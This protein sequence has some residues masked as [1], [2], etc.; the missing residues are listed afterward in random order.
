MQWEKDFK[1]ILIKEEDFV[2]RWKLTEVT[3]AMRR[4]V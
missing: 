1:F 2:W 3:A 4:R